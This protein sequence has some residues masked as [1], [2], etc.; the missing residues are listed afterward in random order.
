MA[1]GATPPKHK[2][3]EARA[4]RRNLRDKDVTGARPRPRAQ[5]EHSRPQDT[6]GTAQPTRQRAYLH[7]TSTTADGR[8]VGQRAQGARANGPAGGRATEGRPPRA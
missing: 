4:E 1:E 5:P 7:R 3:R 2:G 6:F 8:D